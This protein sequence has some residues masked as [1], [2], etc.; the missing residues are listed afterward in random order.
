MVTY[1]W[2]NS[3]QYQETFKP[4]FL[5]ETLKILHTQIMFSDR[6]EETTAG[7]VITIRL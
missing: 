5:E 1:Q 4:S 3:S 7:I 2:P 6:S